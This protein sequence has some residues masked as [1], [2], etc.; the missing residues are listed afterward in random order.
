MAIP[1]RIY[2]I[3]SALEH[4]SHVKEITSL[5]KL[6]ETQKRFFTAFENY[7]KSHLQPT[8]CFLLLARKKL[9]ETTCK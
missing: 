7:F 3:L 8:S 1:F 2:N 9:E 5:Y 6:V 4:K